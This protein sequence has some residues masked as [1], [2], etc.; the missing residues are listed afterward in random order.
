MHVNINSYILRINLL[1]PHSCR[2]R[3]SQSR[4]SVPVL[5]FLFP[6][7]V[8]HEWTRGKRICISPRPT[9]GPGSTKPEDEGR[10]LDVFRLHVSRDKL[11]VGH[12]GCSVTNF[13][14]FI[15]WV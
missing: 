13:T 10:E 12:I 4:S 6:T 1:H 3:S 14:L 15:K 8:G 11:L 9:T 5:P 2:F 7:V